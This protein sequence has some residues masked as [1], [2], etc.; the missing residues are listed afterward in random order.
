MTKPRRP[1]LT[2]TGAE[3]AKTQPPG[4]AVEVGSHATSSAAARVPTTRSPAS[5]HP[6]Y[7]GREQAALCAAQ[8][9]RAAASKMATAQSPRVALKARASASSS[10][11][12]RARTW[13]FSLGCGW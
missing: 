7:S 4:K 9:R 12:A 3:E 2:A 5:V 1:G 13:N 10:P 8:S 11:A 6:Q